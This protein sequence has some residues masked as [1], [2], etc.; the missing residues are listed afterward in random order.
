MHCVGSVL[1]RNMWTKPIRIET[2][3]GTDRDLNTNKADDDANPVVDWMESS[4][5]D[6]VA[7]R[8]KQYQAHLKEVA[9][10]VFPG[11]R[12]SEPSFV[13]GA[14]RPG[15]C[16][17]HY[18]DYDNLAMVIQGRKVFFITE[19]ENI[20]P[21]EGDDNERRD[22]TPYDRVHR[23]WLRVELGAGDVLYLPSG[24]WH[25]VE[26]VPHSVMTNYWKHRQDR[27]TRD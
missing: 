4:T 24:W 16:Y 25:Y 3:I 15:G 22:I 1:L 10:F 26:S 20:E 18:D 5:G 19:H 17:T 2:S 11:V 14:I 23:G 27:V 8:F 12:S 7:L 21:R 9:D 13:T 6:A